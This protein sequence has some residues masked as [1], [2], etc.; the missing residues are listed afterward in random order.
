MEY[1]TTAATNTLKGLAISAVL[2]NHYLNLNIIGNYT[3]FANLAIAIFFI[4]SGY[5]LWYSLQRRFGNSFSVR[6]VLRFY[7]DR[8]IRILPLLWLAWIIQTAVTGEELSPWILA[9]VHGHEHYWFIPSLIHCYLFAPVLFLG[10]RKRWWKSAAIFISLLLLINGLRYSGIL[11]QE[12]IKSIQW[13]NGEYRDIL[14]LHI[15]LFQVGMMLAYFVKLQPEPAAKSK[16]FPL[17]FWSVVILTLALMIFLKYSTGDSTLAKGAWQVV[18]LIPLVGLVYYGIS[19]RSA[20]RPLAFFG[21]ISYA[22]YLF[23][24]TLIRGVSIHGGYPMNSSVELSI[25]VGLFPVFLWLAW[26][27]ERLGSRFAL[28]IRQRIDN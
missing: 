26:I 9:G 8:A 6:S 5:G 24:P 7:F 13:I 28:T 10:M 15:F 22:V 19:H 3:G 17:R 20:S 27:L 14:F 2:I 23:H 12:L 11:P 1:T 25:V 4:L 16:Q 21:S 18:P